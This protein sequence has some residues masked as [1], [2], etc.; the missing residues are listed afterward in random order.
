MIDSL[1]RL[2]H[3][4]VP[5]DATAPVAMFFDQPHHW[6][7]RNNQYKIGY[8]PWE[9][10]KL[11]DDWVGRMNDCDEVWTPSPLIAKWYAEDGVKKPIYVYEHGVD[12]VWTPKK[13][14]PTD[15]IRF[16]H[17]GAE[18]S[19]K[20]G[21]ETLR[22]FRRAFANRDDVELTLKMVN[23]G[24]SLDRVGKTSIV[25][26]KMPLA[27]LIGLFHDHHVFVYPSY[28]EGFGLNP[29]QAMSTGMPTICTGAWAPY[30]RFLDPN[31]TLDSKLV[32]S[33]WPE[34]HPGKMWRPSADEIIDKMRWVA[35]NYDQAHTF[36]QA[37]TAGIQVEYDWDNLTRE[38]FDS[39]AKRL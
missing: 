23:P 39:L 13:R 4:V 15:K 27:E 2:G 8:H 29:L 11:K 31:L 34:V 19:R 37:Q 38:A 18:A 20:G 24:W 26:R 21:W 1:L 35:D 32:K 16:L 12:K 25:N 33:P 30:E 5:N 10:T 14:Q 7:W 3:T 17:V 6:E 9:S 36:A 28:G 22:L